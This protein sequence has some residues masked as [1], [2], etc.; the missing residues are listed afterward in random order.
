MVWWVRVAAA[1]AALACVLASLLGVA[2]CEEA[3]NGIDA[4]SVEQM[5]NVGGAASTGLFGGHGRSSMKSI[6]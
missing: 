3:P 2:V 4:F 6:P 5:S 1:S